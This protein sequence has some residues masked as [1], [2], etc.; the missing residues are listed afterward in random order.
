VN[1]GIGDRVV[2]SYTSDF[3]IDPTNLTDGLLPV[4]RFVGDQMLAQ[5]VKDGYAY[6]LLPVMPQVASSIV[7]VDP[8]AEL[9]LLGEQGR[10]LT[11]LRDF[12]LLQRES[13]PLTCRAAEALSSDERARFDE[14]VNEDREGTNSAAGCI[15]AISGR[16]ISNAAAAR[17]PGTSLTEKGR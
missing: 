13:G 12:D 11:P 8:Q 5:G 1:D 6:A 3:L 15:Y 7:A 4:N 10:F 17:H 16:F 14:L 9:D 2:Q